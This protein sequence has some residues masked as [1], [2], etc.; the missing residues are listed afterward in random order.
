MIAKCQWIVETCAS[1]PWKRHV[2]PCGEDAL[3]T[4]LA[5]D[6]IPF[7]T[8]CGAHGEMKLSQGVKL[9]LITPESWYGGNPWRQVLSFRPLTRAELEACVLRRNQPECIVV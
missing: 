9:F 6:G 5:T 8:F 2:K 1:L 4:S 3:V 7:E